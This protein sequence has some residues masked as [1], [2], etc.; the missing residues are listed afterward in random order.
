MWISCVLWV[1]FMKTFKIKHYEKTESGYIVRLGNGV[2]ANFNTLIKTKAFLADTN[3]FLADT[4]FSVNLIYSRSYTL[5]RTMFVLN[6]RFQ[7]DSLCR[8]TFESAET[9]MYN[10]WHKSELVAGNTLCFTDLKKALGYLER[11]LDNFLPFANKRSDTYSR[12]LIEALKKDIV[13]QKL[14]I[15]NYAKIDTEKLS[16]SKDHAELFET[17]FYKSKSVTV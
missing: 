12:H 4:F 3:R 6:D 17:L 9:V 10:S 16:D 5:W 13:I 14:A 7:F 15:F 2:K 8:N 1:L 11:I